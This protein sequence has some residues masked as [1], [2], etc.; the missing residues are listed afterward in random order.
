[1]KGQ[2]IDDTDSKKA[3]VGVGLGYYKNQQQDFSVHGA[4]I[5]GSEINI[6]KDINKLSDLPQINI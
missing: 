2:S 5:T 6:N 3:A 1:M 4:G